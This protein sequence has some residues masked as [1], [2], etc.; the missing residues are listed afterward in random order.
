MRKLQPVSFMGQAAIF[1]PKLACVCQESVLQYRQI[2]K[3]SHT[4]GKLM[5][6]DFQGI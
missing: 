5:P 1:Y 3:I 2:Y 6:S 4:G